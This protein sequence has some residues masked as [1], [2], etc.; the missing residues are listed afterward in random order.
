MPN[1]TRRLAALALV[2]LGGAVQARFHQVCFEAPPLNVNGAWQ[3][4]GIVGCAVDGAGSCTIQGNWH[5]RAQSPTPIAGVDSPGHFVHFAFPSSSG[6]F[7]AHIRFDDG[8]G[9][10]FVRN[11]EIHAGGR[12]ATHRGWASPGAVLTGFS[13]DASGLVTSAVWRSTTGQNAPFWWHSVQAPADFVAVG[14]GGAGVAQPAGALLS[15]ST[16]YAQY[17]GDFRSWRVRTSEAAGAPQPHVATAYVIGLRVAGLAASDLAQRLQAT[18]GYAPR[19]HLPQAALGPAS[20]ARADAVQSVIGGSVVL[21]GGFSATANVGAPI[22]TQIGQF[23]YLSEPLYGRAIVCPRGP[24][25]CEIEP[26][27]IGWS[28]AS[29]DHVIAAPGSIEAVMLALPRQLTVNGQTYRVTSRHVSATS[30]EAAQPAA[31]ASGLRGQYALTGIGAS[32]AR[33]PRQGVRPE[34]LPP[35]DAPKR[36]D[37]P[38]RGWNGS[39]LWKLEPRPDLGGASVAAKDHVVPWPA[40]VT[41]HAIGIRLEP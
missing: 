2:C 24:T 29:K 9:N 20:H 18:R 1:T 36:V 34:L 28:A 10:S 38:S 15:V 21:G 35:R 7:T 39:L 6:T 32:V 5:R 13:T 22:G 19:N 16:P 8:A 17:P 30:G 25:A 37:V 12:H 33:A 14:G 41:A 31:D 3:A 11:C 27:I 40:Q 23:A 4:T 26:W